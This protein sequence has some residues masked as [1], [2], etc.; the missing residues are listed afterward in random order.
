MV[1]TRKQIRNIDELN[2][3]LEI[4]KCTI[5][6]HFTKYGTHEYLQCLLIHYLQRLIIS[7]RLGVEIN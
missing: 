6:K 2:W 3:K 5:I 1:S 7:E 4:P